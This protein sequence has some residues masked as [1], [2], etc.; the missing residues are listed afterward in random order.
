ML[1]FKISL[2]LALSAIL[3]SFSISA[4]ENYQ[5]G[6]IVQLNGDTLNGYIDYRNWENNPSKIEFKQ[7]E[8]GPVT[9]FRPML[10]K[11]FGVGGEIYHSAIIEIET[12]PTAINSLD[13]YPDLNIVVDTAFIT[14]L[15]R[16][17][18]SLLSYKSR[19]RK[20]N[21]YIE[22]NGAYT[23]LRQKK[24]LLKVGSKTMANENKRYIGQLIL[25][26]AGCGDMESHAQ[27]LE[28]MNESLIRYF[29]T[30]YECINGSKDFEMKQE[31]IRLTAGIS[32]G[33]TST[34]LNLIGT[35]SYPD[36]VFNPSIDFSGGI[37]M[38]CLLGRNRQ[39]WSVFNELNY[40][41]FS[42]ETKYRDYLK[43]YV[44]ARMDFS[45]IKLINMLRFSYPIKEARIF[46][47]AGIT[48]GIAIER[49]NY[50]REAPE[51]GLSVLI[52]QQRLLTDIRKLDIGFMAGAGVQYK[53]LSGEIR[54][55]A[56]DGMSPYIDISSKIKRLYFL[57][58]YRILF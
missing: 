57:L 46:A 20:E 48:Y 8:K 37:Y 31:N 43:D 5:P 56:S 24:Y 39:K 19:N 40:S 51:S 50:L 52:T 29:N 54:Y 15:V 30:Y 58:G 6:Y 35:L 26:L 10:V 27:K 3:L 4:Q 32:A 12:S 13:E 42:F 14:V 38:N 17:T 23:L 28:Y 21:F 16:G 41:S 22:E 9:I 53:R 45:Y 7:S 25:Y 34:K 36:P 33:I 18:K 11:G 44:T 2:L 47:N 1:Y 55:E 49:E